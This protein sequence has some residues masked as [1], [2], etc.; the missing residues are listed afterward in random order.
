MVGAYARASKDKIDAAR[1]ISDRTASK[2]IRLAIKPPRIASS[3]RKAGAALILAPDPFTG[4]AGVFM[5]GAS[6]VAKKREAAGLEELVRETANTM[7]A[8]QSFL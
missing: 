7:R 1:V 2:S 5:V 4:V 8:L 3:L 6:F